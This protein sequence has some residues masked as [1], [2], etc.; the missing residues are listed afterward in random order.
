[1]ATIT[2]TEDNDFLVG[3]P[4]DDSIFGL[5]GTDT[6]IG[7]E[8]NDTLDGGEDGFDR[9]DYRTSPAAIIATFDAAAATGI[10]QDGFGS[11]DTLIAIE[12]ITGSDFN[13]TITGGAGNEFV[14]AVGGDDV[15]TGG[16]GYDTLL[17]IIAP[18]GVTVNLESGT[19]SG[20]NGNDTFTGFE[21]VAGSNFDDVLIGSNSDVPEDFEG[22]GGNDFIDGGGGAENGVLY[23]DSPEG[24]NV[25][26]TTGKAEDGLGTVDTLV[27]IQNVIG[28]SVDDVLIGDKSN[29]VFTPL[30]GSDRIDGRG[31]FDTV[32]F[33]N[34]S[35]SP[36]GV[37]VDL[38]NGFSIDGEGTERKILH[39]EEVVGSEFDDIVLG[40]R[41]DNIFVGVSGND[42]FD[43]RKGTDL[44]VL[45]GNS[46]EF[47][48]AAL[49]GVV[50]VKDSQGQIDTYVNVEFLEFNDITIAT[51]DIPV[52]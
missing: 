47:E 50:T 13:D 3:T 42:F 7:A 19:A 22:R 9:A 43:G 2:G 1:M 14:G 10:V 12:R 45:D 34:W 8:G 21:A 28:S 18:S 29:N 38:R 20:G 15:L 24:V 39:I 31:G 49:S 4:E 11:T 51:A 35:P 27:N 17:Y 6:I 46:D 23:F 37:L 44:A 40:N 52:G 32:N 36:V 30:G 41:A 48:I 33:V 25:N 5:G 16:D 26:L